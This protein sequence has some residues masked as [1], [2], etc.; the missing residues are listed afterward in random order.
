VKD[1]SRTDVRRRRIRAGAAALI[2]VGVGLSVHILMDGTAGDIIGDALY[3]T[4]IYLLTVCALPRLARG[5]AALLAAGFCTAIELLQITGA[6]RAWAETFPPIALVFGAG[7]D[8]RDLVVYAA[9]I[10]VAML[11][12]AAAGRPRNS[13]RK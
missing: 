4:L 6:P 12:D 5:W 10:A 9:A 3:A 13:L 11:I 2:T 1:L 7:F 8:V